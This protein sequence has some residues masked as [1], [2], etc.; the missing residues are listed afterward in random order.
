M[1]NVA[2]NLTDAAADEIKRLRS[3]LRKVLKAIQDCEDTHSIG[4]ISHELAALI[5]QEINSD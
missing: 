2:D 1:T 4:V 3:V 5:D